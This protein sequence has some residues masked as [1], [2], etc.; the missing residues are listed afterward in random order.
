MSDLREGF[1]T[2]LGTPL[3]EEGYIIENSLRK[4]IRSQKEAGAAGL[5]LMGSM[6]IES[7]IRDSQYGKIARIAADT[8][9]G[10]IPL[11]VGA[12][13]NSVARVLDRADAL[14]KIQIDGIVV[15][16]PFY[17]VSPEDELL[18]FFDGIADRSYYPVYLY[19]LPGVTKQK[20]TFDMVQKL[21]KHPNIRGIKTADTALVRSIMGSLPGFQAFYSNLDCFDVGVSYGI[22][23]VLDGMFCCTP[24]NAFQMKQAFWGG[25]VKDGTKH[26]NRIL[27]FRDF[28]LRC[29]LL[30]SF[31]AA[32]NLLGI[33]GNFHP[34]YSRIK[35]EEK[36]E[37][38]KNK[39]LEIGEL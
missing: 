7:A 16:T 19:D 14:G 34:D 6:G 11:F 27:D 25:N 23:K 2:A 15:T 18:N 29:R 31:T 38:V 17:S 3:D 37:L 39:M 20:I 22:S 5:L 4:H 1:Y 35:G 33:K 10:H 13:D 9:K 36:S 8:V 32:M 26:L 30:P 24:K 28:L 12:M 21:A